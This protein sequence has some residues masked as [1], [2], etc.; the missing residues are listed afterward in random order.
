[1][2]VSSEL[3]SCLCQ[4]LGVNGAQNS[5]EGEQQKPH[6]RR[7]HHDPFPLDGRGGKR[8][9]KCQQRPMRDGVSIEQRRHLSGVAGR[10]GFERQL[11]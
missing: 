10:C 1:M 2:C 7:F 8:S 11:L 3:M 9:N 4:R 6:V 5:G